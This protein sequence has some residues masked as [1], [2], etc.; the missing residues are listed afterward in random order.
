MYIISEAKAFHFIFMEVGMLMM[1]KTIALFTILYIT[2][3]L[4]TGCARPIK[5]NLD[6]K[7]ILI[8]KKTLPLNVALIKFSDMRLDEER[9]RPSREREGYTDTGDYTYDKLFKGEVA[10]TITAMLM[11]HVRYA[12]VFSRI[13]QMSTSSNDIAQ[14]ELTRL[15]NAGFDAV[16]TGNLE[17]FFGYYDRNFGREFLYMVPMF[18]SAVASPFIVDPTDF[19]ESLVAALITVSLGVGGAYLESLHKRDIEWKTRLH[20]KLVRISTSDL[21]WEDELEVS[22]KVHKSMPGFSGSKRKVVI[23]SLRDAINKM[24][25]SLSELSL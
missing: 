8:S 15:Q 12:R 6:Q 23:T 1:R 3:F 14:E 5:Y 4:I 9:F 20:L 22:G 17:N 18:G 11:E 25:K 2:F 21:I 19:T 24:V 13:Q 7:I 10:E 16:L